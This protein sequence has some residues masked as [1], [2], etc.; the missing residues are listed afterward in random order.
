M[1]VR[2]EHLCQ[3]E[4]CPVDTAR[5]PP[6]SFW[7]IPMQGI[8]WTCMFSLWDEYLEVEFLRHR[9]NV[10]L[11]F[12]KSAK[13][14][15]KP[16][17]FTLYWPYLRAMVKSLTTLVLSVF[18]SYWHSSQCVEASHCGFNCFSLMIN[19]TEQF[20]LSCCHRVS[21]WVTVQLLCPFLAAY[22]LQ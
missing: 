15:P 17:H 5:G 19:G 12:L 14:F 16:F 6:Q 7:G 20:S 22:L 8:L 1:C 3:W 2:S 13:Y 11:T 9:E 18:S 21:S 4:V 10:C